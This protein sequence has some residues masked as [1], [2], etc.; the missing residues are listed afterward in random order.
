MTSETSKVL[1]IMLFGG[2]FSLQKFSGYYFSKFCPVFQKFSFKKFFLK[3]FLKIC[4]ENAFRPANPSLGPVIDITGEGDPSSSSMNH[5]AQMRNNYSNAIQHRS[6]FYQTQP[7]NQQQQQLR[8]SQE[9]F[10][11]KFLRILFFEEFI[12]SINLA[13]HIYKI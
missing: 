2:H 8:H 5:I 7:N 4:N 9:S 10:S 11:P 13:L 1:S 6:E 3:T 12:F